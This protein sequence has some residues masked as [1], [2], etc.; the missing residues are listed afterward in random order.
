VSSSDGLSQVQSNITLAESGNLNTFW[1]NE[2]TG[3]WHINF[4]VVDLELGRNFWISKWLTLRPFTGLKFDWTS[5]KFNVQYSDIDVDNI[6]FT[7][8]SDGADVNIKM[9]QSQWAAGLRAG[10]NTAWYLWNKWCVYGD[11]ALSGMVNHF[12]VRRTDEVT[13]SSGGAWTQNNIRNKRA[14]PMTAV[15]EWALGLRFE[16]AFHNDD[17][18]FQFQAGWENQV[19]F[20]QNQF[21]FFPNNAGSSDLSFQG[22]TVKAAFYF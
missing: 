9:R 11:F 22:L 10:L 3:K 19:W 15:L 6:M 20:N 8:L 1:A 18:M 16:T 12:N 14:Q 5:Q 7:N 4:N 13:P 21:I 2:A 17:Y